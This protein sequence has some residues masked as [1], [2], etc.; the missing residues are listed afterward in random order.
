MKKI[1]ADNFFLACI[2]VLAGVYPLIRGGWDL[3]AQSAAQM[4]FICVASVWLL[5]K[6]RQGHSPALCN[7]G[8]LIT[9]A[10]GA[11][12]I[13]YALSPISELCFAELKNWL[14]GISAIIFL[15][16]INNS[17]KIIEKFIIYG[18]LTLAAAALYQRFILSDAHA[19]ATF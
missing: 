10:L 13:S 2:A 3:W 5:A 16:R 6:I 1:N 17:R 4:F 18:A 15:P 9:I 19:T 14:L 12:F 11:G 7:N 8:V